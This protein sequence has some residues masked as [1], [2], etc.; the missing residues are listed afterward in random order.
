[1]KNYDFNPLRAAQAEHPCC[2]HL[3]SHQALG[4]WIRIAVSSE[5]MNF[6]SL[7]AE[8]HEAAISR[9]GLHNFGGTNYRQAMRVLLLA[10]DTDVQLTDAGRIGV[11]N[12]IL[13]SLIARLHT[14]EGWSRHPHVLDTPISSPLVIIGLPRS[15]TTALHRLLSVDPQF[16]GLPL[17]LSQ[18]PMMRPPM[19]DWEKYPAYRACVAAI[20][21]FDEQSPDHQKIHEHTAHDVEECLWILMQSFLSHALPEIL[22]LHSYVNWLTPLSVQSSY[23]RYADVLRLIGAG[24][25][26][27]RWLLKC[28]Y[29]MSAI[30]SLLTVFPDANLI[31]TH[32][33]PL[34]AIPSFCSLLYSGRRKMQELQPSTLGLRQCSYWRDALDKTNSTRRN[35]SSRCFDVDYRQF[36]QNPMNTVRSLYERFGLAFSANAETK[37][38]AVVALSS[39]SRRGLHQYATEDRKSV[40]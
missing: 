14:E 29:H 24:E 35:I 10:F 6:D 5:Y 22:G 2:G 33:D 17:W 30:D 7:E 39:K 26:N 18:A 34:E 21:E 40:V 3:R 16:Q 9:T 12:F 11:R 25:P 1:M 28:P 13:D 8:L 15:G 4:M 36:V 19:R 37:M 32:R 23:L 38:N 31:Q 27:K 20:K